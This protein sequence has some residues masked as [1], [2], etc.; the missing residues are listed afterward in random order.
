MEVW[1]ES[2]DR[3]SEPPRRGR[4]RR[5]SDWKD[6]ALFMA[7]IAGLATVGGSFLMLLLSSLGFTFSG[8]GKAIADI[9]AGDVVRD[10][11]ISQIR[12]S[13]Q[14]VTYMVCILFAE[15]HP[16]QVPRACDQ[17]VQSGGR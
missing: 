5:F 4:I 7:E 10:S 3:R 6:F 8:S 13:Q 2:N 1:D 11:A 9:R 14:P 17:A 12:T 16:R 15:Q